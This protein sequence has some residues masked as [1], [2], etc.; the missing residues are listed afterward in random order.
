MIKVA[1][2]YEDFQL[3]YFMAERVNLDNNMQMNTAAMT[4]ISEKQHESRGMHCCTCRTIWFY[5]KEAYTIFST[6]S[7]KER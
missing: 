7:Y 3:Q 4:K 2:F 1:E 5:S 6:Q